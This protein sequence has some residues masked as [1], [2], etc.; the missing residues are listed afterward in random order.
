MVLVGLALLVVSCL[1]M[2]IYFAGVSQVSQQA[3]QIESTGVTAPEGMDVMEHQVFPSIAV[4]NVNAKIEWSSNASVLNV[5]T[6]A[7]IEDCDAKVFC[8][9]F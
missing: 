1:S 3:I 2:G 4:E 5:N 7:N 8:L 9:I 6:D